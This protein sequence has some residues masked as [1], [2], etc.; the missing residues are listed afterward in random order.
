MIGPQ[1]PSGH[2]APDCRGGGDILEGDARGQEQ[3]VRDSEGE[4]RMMRSDGVEGE[5]RAGQSPAPP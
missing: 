2:A 5:E 4:V 3:R 1:Q